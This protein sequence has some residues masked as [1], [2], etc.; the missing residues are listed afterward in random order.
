MTQTND[1]LPF[2]LTQDLSRIV[3][4]T[5]RRTPQGR[6]KASNDIVTKGYIAAGMRLTERVLGPGAACPPPKG[7]DDDGPGIPTLLAWLSQRKV[8][9]EFGNNTGPL[10]RHG[11]NA[12][13]L[14]RV[15]E[16]HSNFI[17]DLMTFG[18]WSEHYVGQ[19]KDK[20]AELAE[21]L[22]TRSDTVEAAHELCYWDLCALVAMPT[23]R[24]QLVASVVAEQDEVIAAALSESYRGVLQMWRPVHDAVIKAFGLRLRPGISLDDLSNLFTALAEGFAFRMTAEPNAAV[25]DHDRHRTLYGT[26]CLAIFASCVVPANDA[27]AT[28]LEQHL[29]NLIH[30][31]CAGRVTLAA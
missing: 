29:E 25:I 16:P 20:I 24:L 4:R 5:N 31:R 27:P 3:T 14:R 12:R 8:A 26:G 23:W 15:W 6:A 21:G 17:A 9:D 13:A 18:L 19:Y 7:E 10:P 1:G 11:G 2:A 22:L 28:T 30:P